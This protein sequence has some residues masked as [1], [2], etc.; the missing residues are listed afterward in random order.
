MRSNENVFQNC[1]GKSIM[2]QDLQS[3]AS[4][5]R[6]RATEVVCRALSNSCAIW[7]S[8]EIEPV[9]ISTAAASRPAKVLDSVETHAGIRGFDGLPW[10]SSGEFRC[11]GAD[12]SGKSAYGHA[13]KP[14]RNTPGLGE[15][16]TFSLLCGR[17]L[18][19]TNLT[20]TC[21]AASVSLRNV[22][23]RRRVSGEAK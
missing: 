3:A 18:P 19:R 4:P 9:G 1:V 5:L 16:C 14:G 22:L 15:I 20:D 6:H 17:L 2:H 21:Q 13:R 10:A 11:Q 23:K 12:H 7:S 8:P